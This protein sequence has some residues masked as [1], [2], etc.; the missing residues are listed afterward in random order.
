MWHRRI[1]TNDWAVVTR[2]GYAVLRS[3]SDHGTLSVRQLADASAMDPATASRQLQQLVD[4]G[5]VRRTA[6]GEDARSIEL[7]LTDRGR[8]VYERVAR[9]RVAHLADVLKGWSE[10]DRAVLSDLALRLVRDL[11][12]PPRLPERRPR[13]AS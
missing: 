7:S 13:S 10:Q 9:Y 11:A 12:G 3:L 5:L 1:A 6:H 2:A 4:E 8:K